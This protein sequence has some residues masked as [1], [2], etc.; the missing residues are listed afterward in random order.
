MKSFF[1]LVFFTIIFVSNSNCS[2]AIDIF[3]MELETKQV[4]SENTRD[5]LFVS[6]GSSCEICHQLRAL[7]LR[8]VAFPLDWVIS[9][10]NAGLIRLLEDDFL[11]YI[12]EKYLCRSDNGSLLNTCYHIEF[13]H[14]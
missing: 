7:D 11:Y 5:P 3:D 14:E 12:D 6:L 13:P 8:I 1:V 10:D 9:I 4:P 2:Y